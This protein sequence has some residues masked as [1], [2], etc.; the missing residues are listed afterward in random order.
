MFECEWTATY[1]HLPLKIGQTLS[2]DSAVIRGSY[3]DSLSA[4]S[5]RHAARNSLLHSP[6]LMS[7]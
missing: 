5:L 6:A 4:F 3:Y 1:R 7:L 2:S